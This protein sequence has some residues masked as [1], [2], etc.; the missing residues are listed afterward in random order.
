MSTRP[1]ADPWRV[2]FAAMNEVR[3]SWP[4]HGWS[5]DARLSCVSSSFGVEFEGRARL[6]A[7]LA[8]PSQWTPKT[9][10]Q[11]PPALRDIAERTGGLRE[12]QV[13][14][15]SDGAGPAFGYGL[16]WPWGDETTTSFRIGLAGRGGTPDMLKRLRDVFGAVEL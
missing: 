14:F 4:S 13:I 5:W 3:S 2:L 15:A 1:D 8:L 16:W 11:A 9:L 12:G 7:S 10:L 6:A